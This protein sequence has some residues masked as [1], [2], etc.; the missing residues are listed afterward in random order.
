MSLRHRLRVLV[1]CCALQI[2]VL[3][4]MPMVPDEIREL[5][6]IPPGWLSI[7]ARQVPD[8]YLE[9]GILRFP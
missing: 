1:V 7:S 8:A 5:L 3:M 9:P 4:G 6:N 2:G